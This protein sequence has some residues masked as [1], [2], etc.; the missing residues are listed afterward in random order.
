[1][2]Q[3]V[4][5]DHPVNRP[6]SLSFEIEREHSHHPDVDTDDNARQAVDFAD[7]PS[8]ARRDFGQDASKESRDALRPQNRPERRPHFSAAVGDQHRVGR[9]QVQEPWDVAGGERFGEF[10]L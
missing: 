7:L 5:V 1:M 3:F 9:Q 2:P 10:R 6:D 4:R 8:D